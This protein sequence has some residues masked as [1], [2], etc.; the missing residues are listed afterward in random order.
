M[1]GRA[2]RSKALRLRRCPH[3]RRSVPPMTGGLPAA[4][5]S[6]IQD[7]EASA[8]NSRLTVLRCLFTSR[9]L[10][11]YRASNLHGPSLPM[12][13]FSPDLF[14]RLRQGYTR[15][16]ANALQH[17][18]GHPKHPLASR[19]VPHGSNTGIAPRGFLHDRAAVRP[20]NLPRIRAI[21]Y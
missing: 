18:A 17:P 2:T 8:L 10:M 5:D 20:P 15:L 11:P 19:L 13:G 9:T 1:T 7:P 14:R 3:F 12:R 21:Q 4:P 6:Q 16:R